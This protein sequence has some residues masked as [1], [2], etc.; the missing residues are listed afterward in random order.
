MTNNNNYD[1]ITNP[2]HTKQR[3][4][5]LYHRKYHQTKLK[6]ALILILYKNRNISILISWKSHKICIILYEKCFSFF[7][8]RVKVFFLTETQMRRNFATLIIILIFMALLY[9]YREEYNGNIENMN[10]PVYMQ[11]L[12]GEEKRSS[13]T[14]L[15]NEI[16]F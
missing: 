7:F 6:A 10:Y 9:D 1:K 14:L 11:Y 15:F 2:P 5:N 3:K 16:T 8:F 12:G 13:Y 4:L